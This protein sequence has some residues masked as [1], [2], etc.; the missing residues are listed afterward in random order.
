MLRV[1][2]GPLLVTAAEMREA[3][4]VAMA[5]DI[6][7]EVL[8]AR[9]ADEAARVILQAMPGQAALVLCGPGNNGGDGFGVATRLRAAGIAVRIAADQLPTAGP[10]AAFAAPWRDAFEPFATVGD[11]TLIIDAVFGTGLTRPLPPAVAAMFDRLRD[12]RA[13]VIALD[14]P[15]GIDSDTGAALGM[16]LAADLTIAFGGLKRGHW[17]GDGRKLSGRVE[18]VD[19]GV[20]VPGQVRGLIA[21]SMTGIDKISHK[22]QLVGVLV[23]AGE[24]AGAT[25]LAALAALRAGAGAVTLVGGCGGVPA[26][27]IMAASDAAALALLG[28]PKV[29]AVALGPGLD[30]TERGRDWLQRLLGGQTP[31]VLDAGAL[32]LCSGPRNV[33]ADAAAPRVL[34]P[35]DGEFARLFGPPGADRVGAVQAAA[36]ISGGI[37][38]LKGRETIIAS[39]DGRVAINNHATPWLATAGS[40]D[41]LTG[42]IAALLAQGLAPFDAAQAGAWLHGDAG[43]RGGPGLIADDLP[44]LLVDVLKGL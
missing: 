13:M 25:R 2:P 23:I 20:S 1:D 43:K 8:M 40:G 38:L 26:D 24:Q 12:S 28:T 42:I 32:A 7:G 44:R 29:R 21:P 39:P 37:V 31:V 10:A 14:L 30:A 41:V 36:V 27:A 5:G 16:P 33:F 19:I 6:T 15:S 17:L 11:E 4:A 18:I 9:A 3:E 35:H 22:Y 34:T